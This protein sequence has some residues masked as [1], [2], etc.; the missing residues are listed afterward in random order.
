MKIADV[1]HIID[2]VVAEFIGGAVTDSAL[3]SASGHPHGKTLD[4]V[5]TT[6]ASL[7][8]EHGSA[9]EFASPDD[10]GVVEQTALLQVRQERPGRSVGQAATDIHIPR[11]VSVMIPTAVVE[12]NEARATLGQST[13]EQAVGRVGAVPGCRAVEIYIYRD[14]WVTPP[15]T[16][17]LFG[18]GNFLRGL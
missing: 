2:G 10:K 13:G 16:A 14:M 15:I 12:M 1:D 8:L 17:P 3:D 18:K 7:A 5:I 6:G 4:V 11:E 9:S